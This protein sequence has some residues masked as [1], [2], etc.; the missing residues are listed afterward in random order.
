[1]RRFLTTIL[2]MLAPCCAS[3]AQEFL[4]IQELPE[5]LEHEEMASNTAEV[6]FIANTDDITITTSNRS[7]DLVA[8][9]VRKSDGLYEYVVMLDLSGGHYDRHF[10]VEKQ[11]STFRASTKRKTIFKTGERRYFFVKEPSLKVMLTQPEIGYHLEK[12]EACIEFRSPYPDLRIDTVGLL[13]L[14]MK[15]NISANNTFVTSII[16]N[17]AHLAKLQSIYADSLSDYWEKMTTLTV[18][19]DSSN[20]NSVSLTPLK[21]RTKLTYA[22][23]TARFGSEDNSE[24]LHLL[25]I[26]F[27]PKDAV[28]RLDGNP[29]PTLNGTAS[30]YVPV[31]KHQYEIACPYFHAA[32]DTLT[33]GNEDINVM[34][35]LTPA[36]GHL[37]IVGDG[38]R[39]ATVFLNGEE[40]GTAPYNSNRLKSGIYKVDLIKDLYLPFTTEITIFDGDTFELTASLVPNYA[41]L[42]F[43]VENDADIF[44]N[45]KKVGRERYVCDLITG[46]YVVEARKSGHASSID[47]FRISPEMMDQVIVL[48]APEP[49]YGLLAIRTRPS[50]ATVWHNDTI[51]CVTPR[52][53][54]MLVGEYDLTITKN[55][56]D[57]VH[58]DINLSNRNCLEV[59]AKLMAIEKKSPNDSTLNLV[60]TKY[61]RTPVG[62]IRGTL[63]SFNMCYTLPYANPS[64]GLTVGRLRRCGW[65]LALNTNFRFKG[66]DSKTPPANSSPIDSCTTH[67]SATLGL[68]VRTCDFLSLRVGAG[69]GY[70]ARNFKMS[71]MHW[72]AQSTSRIASLQTDVGIIFHLNPLTITFDYSTAMLKYHTFRAG[73]GFCI[74]KR[75][76]AQRKQK[77]SR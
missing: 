48:R 67:F 44:I 17:T 3:F 32:S 24:N 30:A 29:L 27:S 41:H 62:Y 42:T 54:R 18:G 58:T 45:D 33:I 37:N 74:Q 36:F 12:D 47:T 59:K 50:K 7:V 61:I 75:P 51:V 2:L 22:I 72:Y 65:S 55:R 57:T 26:S 11:G 68:V 5:K 10:T 52:I 28:V 69:I 8:E 20:T 4:S 53:V 73:I 76:S 64:F 14:R 25:K 43:A 39:G 31:G 13:N 49:I 56:C 15:N 66:L 60:R 21:A 38:A 1:M 23:V 9:P 71:D 40:V 6:I 77:Q 46:T 35:A 19:F 70:Y 16:V 34:V 63:F